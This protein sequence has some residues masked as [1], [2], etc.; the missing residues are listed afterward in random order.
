MPAGPSALIL[1]GEPG[2]GKTALWSH[3]VGSA[4]RLSFAMM[5]SR[6]TQAESD[7]PYTGLGDLFAFLGDETLSELPAPQ[8]R[9]L[10]IALLRA[11]SGSTPLQQRAVAV[12]VLNVL[13]S[14]ARTTPL[15]VAI[16]DLQWLDVPSRRVLQ[17]AVR[18]LSD[19]PIGFLVAMRSGSNE[20]D[21]LGFG[22]A[23]RPEYVRHLHL[24]PLPPT[25][26]E[27]LLRSRLHASLASRLIKRLGEASG[28]NPMFA[29]ELGR[30][31]LDSPEADQPGRPVAI[32][33]SLTEVVGSR[34]S[35]LPRA[36]RECLLVAAAL[37]RPTVELIALASP[38]PTHAVEALMAGVDAGVIALRAGSVSFSHPLL[39]SVAYSRAGA[40]QLRQ[41]HGRLAEL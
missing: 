20:M 23:A 1:Q 34:L 3:A 36:T 4:E 32:P 24:G 14:I 31:L 18:R 8:R 15:L 26:V 40:A 19:E 25:A 21:T 35:R 2:I 38:R 22:A 11:E 13:T 5:T 12:A 7:L 6:P 33:A 30:V 27:R 37:S 39:A 16:D 28:G 41:L 9:S 29:L 17:F 10:E